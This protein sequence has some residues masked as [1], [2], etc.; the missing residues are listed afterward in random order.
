M[1]K[2]SHD[3]K[4]TVW[5]TDRSSRGRFL[6]D[7]VGEESGERCEG[8]SFRT[9]L[10]PW[11]AGD[12]RGTLRSRSFSF[13]LAPLSPSLSRLA[14]HSGRPPLRLPS[15]RLPSCSP[16]EAARWTALHGARSSPILRIALYLFRLSALRSLMLPLLFRPIRGRCDSE[17]LG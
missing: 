16:R 17:R 10:G 5:G 13:S 6:R 7:P 11:R 1:R 8:A 3:I 15:S 9:K 14:V 4:V 12:P 2:R